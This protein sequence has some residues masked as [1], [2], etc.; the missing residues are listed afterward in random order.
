MECLKRDLSLR[1]PVLDARGR[2][3]VEV[4]M[5]WKANKHKALDCK[6][7]WHPLVHSTRKTA[8]LPAFL[9]WGGGKGWKRG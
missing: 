2:K 8:M 4:I 9:T 3:P 5:D 7:N 6:L 1:N